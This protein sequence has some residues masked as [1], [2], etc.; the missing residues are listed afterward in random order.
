VDLYGLLNEKQDDDNFAFSTSLGISF[1]HEL[2]TYQQDEYTFEGDLQL[3][4]DGFKMPV[5]HSAA[6]LFD[7]VYLL[8]DKNENGIISSDVEKQN[9]EIISNLNLLKNRKLITEYHEKMD[10]YNHQEFKRNIRGSSNEPVYA[11]A[12]FAKVR[13]PNKPI[14][15]HAASQ[16]SMS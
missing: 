2:D 6:P 13:R 10:S 11:S 4:E 14:A 8:S 3:T 15:L 9:Y 7:L 16:F 12:G 5:S 1:L